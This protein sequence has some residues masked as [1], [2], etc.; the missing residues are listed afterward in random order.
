MVLAFIA[1][2][3]A[4]ALSSHPLF[5]PTCTCILLH[6]HGYIKELA[7]LVL[8]CIN[9]LMPDVM[10]AP[11]IEALAWKAGLSMAEVCRRAGIAQ[12][13]FTRWK[14]GKTEPTLDA[15]RRLCH[16]VMPDDQ[17]LSLTPQQANMP[18]YPDAPEPQYSAMR[19]HAAPYY[20]PSSPALTAGA[21]NDDRVAMEA[22]EI[23]ARINRELGIEEARADRLLR[24]YNR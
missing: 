19:E 5:A 8:L 14:A 23:F 13:T 11:E 3:P 22:A 16:A 9:A 7:F 20:G 10:T 1:K 4:D 21:A 15:Y 12:S 2:T 6:V 17:K 24:L 18:T